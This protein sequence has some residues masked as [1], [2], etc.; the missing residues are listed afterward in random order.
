MTRKMFVVLLEP[1]RKRKPGRGTTVP[2]V[3]FTSLTT[4]NPKG[5]G[6][7][8][9]WSADLVNGQ[10]YIQNLSLSVNGQE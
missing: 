6:V 7:C 10:G 1:G 4:I 8:T 2:L 5:I 9:N 3:L